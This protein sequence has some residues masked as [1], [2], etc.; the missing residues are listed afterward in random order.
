MRKCKYHMKIWGINDLLPSLVHPDLVLYRL[1]V[2]TVPIPAGIIVDFYMSAILA[3]GDGDP[4]AAGLAVHDGMCC[5]L[6]DREGSRGSTKGFPVLLKD[7]L[8]LILGHD[9]HLPVCP[10]GLRHRLYH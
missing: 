3:L 4:Q 5:L 7:L 1:T 10:G 6:L 2:G 9:I 8:D